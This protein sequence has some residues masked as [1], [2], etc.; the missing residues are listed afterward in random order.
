MAIVFKTELERLQ[1]PQCSLIPQYLWSD[2]QYFNSKISE[3]LLTFMLLD[4]TSIK[5]EL[6]NKDISSSSQ[7]KKT[8]IWLAIAFSHKHLS[9]KELIDFSIKLGLPANVLIQ[10]ASATGRKDILLTIQQSY[11]KN[12]LKFSE[13]VHS[14]LISSYLLA[15]RTGWAEILEYLDAHASKKLLDYL[16][17]DINKT[18]KCAAMG[19]HV[20]VLKYLEPKFPEH[21]RA[22]KAS[23]HSE[24]FQ[25]AAING[26]VN[27][28]RYLELIDPEKIQKKIESGDYFAFHHAAAH[29]Q[30]DVLIYLEE[31]SPSKLQAMI[32]S[33]KYYAVE[34]SMKENHGRVLHFLESKPVFLEEFS[35][36]EQHV[37]EFGSFLSPYCIKKVANL[38][39]QKQKLAAEFDITDLQEA[40]LLFYVLRHLIRINAPENDIQFLLDIPAVAALA[41]AEI[42]PNYPNELLR[43]ALSIKNKN[44]ARML[45]TIPAVHDLAEENDFYLS[46]QSDGIDLRTLAQDNES[47]MKALSHSEETMLE[48]AL[49]Q[50]QAQIT[51]VG[52]NTIFD[53]LMH[54][55]ELRYQQNPACIKIGEKNQV[56]PLSFQEFTKLGLVEPQK[57][58]A[59]KAY[60]QNKDHTAWR[61]LSKPNPW[62]HKNAAY[63]SADKHKPNE[64]WSAFYKY[65]DLIVLLYLATIDDQTPTI[66]GYTFQTRLDHFI[67]ELAYIGRA[68]NWDSKQSLG[69]NDA[70]SDDLECDRPSC[71]SGIKKRLFQS[72]QGHP[73]FKKLTKVILEM[74]INQFVSNH[75]QE[76]IIEENKEKISNIWKK[77]LEMVSL[78]K[79]DWQLLGTLDI[80]E[81]KQKQFTDYLT[82]KYGHQ[83]SDDAML[84]NLVKKS[85]KLKEENS[86]HLFEFGHIHPER[87]FETKPAT[88]ISSTPDGFFNV[89]SN[90][91]EPSSKPTSVFHNSI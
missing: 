87:F 78:D 36:M 45:L 60:F 67:E 50:Y 51:A 55:L 43:L 3:D 12:P 75:F 49:K 88:R 72:I 53:N 32:K 44:A 18:Y 61:F 66:D 2:K 42:T 5:N 11:I 20:A 33:N 79:T 7:T 26:H 9:A 56:L 37:Y 48:D 74:E 68:H 19:G 6:S 46:E 17:R 64:K 28:L 70:E 69:K 65:K 63:V 39:E 58:Q 59:L 54:T 34:W 4:N 38:R 81:A 15:V 76:C 30:V 85:F 89:T 57:T 77:K 14:V 47:A 84:T 1:H 22:K 27:V 35:S 10:L 8:C 16:Q 40:K 80:A 23:F 21:L 86:A 82:N 91:Q 41:H 83:F 90:N 13:L 24:A 62:M 73:L 25:W 52:T 31:K 29:D 71:Y